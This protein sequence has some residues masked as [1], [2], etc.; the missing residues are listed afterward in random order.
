MVTAY[1]A[2]LV[3][4]QA[5]MQRKEGDKCA[6][7]DI[8]SVRQYLKV[9]IRGSTE[10][11]PVIETDSLPTACQSLTQPDEARAGPVSHPEKWILGEKKAV[12]ENILNG[13][14]V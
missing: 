12:G 9:N 1:L 2:L 8:I 3:H 10:I 14:R 11:R 7:V 5:H 6:G 13:G 4:M